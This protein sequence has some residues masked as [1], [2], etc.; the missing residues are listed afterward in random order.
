MAMMEPTTMTTTTT[1]ATT[2]DDAAALQRAFRQLCGE[3]EELVDEASN[4][5]QPIDERVGLA[6]FKIDEACAVTD[7]VREDAAQAQE[8]LME[9]LIENCHEL[10][11]IFL[12]I[13][14]MEVRMTVTV[15]GG[16]Y[17]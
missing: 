12:R 13:N 5:A 2:A 6:L 9:A 16:L 11:D 1:P 8:Q 3:Y 14:I 15:V 10:E 7:V 17:L 4:G